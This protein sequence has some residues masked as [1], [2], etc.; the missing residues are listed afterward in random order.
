VSNLGL[1]RHAIDFL[2]TTDDGKGRWT[3]GLSADPGHPNDVRRYAYF[4]NKDLMLLP[5]A[6][7]D[8][9]CSH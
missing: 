6:I 9:V 4:G 1:S 2:T 7:V 8:A 3:S 5:P